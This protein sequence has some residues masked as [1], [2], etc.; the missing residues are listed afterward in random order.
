[1]PPVLATPSPALVTG[2][3]VDRH[4]ATGRQARYR[5]LDATIP[6]QLQPAITG[7]LRTGGEVS[8]ADSELHTGGRRCQQADMP[9]LLVQGL[10]NVPPEHH[11]HPGIGI[12]SGEQLI[13]VVQPQLLQDLK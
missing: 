4:K 6:M 10:V 9:A 5:G 12:Q 8:T 3:A 2:C 11:P 13:A 1:M 7:G